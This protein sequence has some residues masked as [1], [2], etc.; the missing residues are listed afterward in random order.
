MRNSIKLVLSSALIVLC[1][2]NAYSA[3]LIKP[4]YEMR[5]VWLATVEGI[6]WPSVRDQ[7]TD[8][9]SEQEPGYKSGERSRYK[10]AEAAYGNDARLPG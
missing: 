9:S 10:Q 7:Q 5:S 1:G 2:I 4:K 8:A 3:D 6:D